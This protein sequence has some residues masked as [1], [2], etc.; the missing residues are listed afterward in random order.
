[1]SRIFALPWSEILNKPAIGDL[2][3]VLPL[4]KLPAHTHSWSDISGVLPIDKLPAHTHSNLVPYSGAT[5]AL[6]LGSQNLLT[7]GNLTANRVFLG[8]TGPQLDSSSGTIRA[9][10]NAN[11]ADAPFSA[12]NITSSGVG[13][14]A[15]SSSSA[16]VLSLADTWSSSGVNYTGL[17]FNTTRTAQGSSSK[18]F[19]FQSNGVDVC[20]LD[21]NGAL[22]VTSFGGTRSILAS[23]AIN[24]P[25]YEVSSNGKLWFSDGAAYSTAL[26]AASSGVLQLT[27][28]TSGTYRDLLLQNLTASGSVNL[29]TITA[30]VKSSNNPASTASSTTNSAVMVTGLRDGVEQSIKSYRGRWIFDNSA[31]GPIITIGDPGGAENF[32]FLG[33]GLGMPIGSG[34]IGLWAQHTCRFWVSPAACG[35]TNALIGW[36]TTPTIWLDTY[37]KKNGV[38]D[39]SLCQNP[40]NTGEIAANF[41]TGGLTASGNVTVGGTTAPTIA[42]KNASN[43]TYVQ[44]DGTNRI[45]FAGGDAFAVLTSDGTT[46][47]YNNGA[48]AWN[49]TSVASSGTID[50]KLIRSATAQVGVR[51]DAGLQVMNLAGSAYTTLYCNMVEV[52]PTSSSIFRRS[53]YFVWRNPSDG[54]IKFANWAETGGVHMDFT[55]ADCVGIKN[56]ANNG[57]GAL[58]QGLVSSTAAANTTSLPGG[59]AWWQDTTGNTRR[60]NYNDSGVIYRSPL[61]I[62]G[63]YDHQPTKLCDKRQLVDRYR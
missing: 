18:F 61:L 21:S 37:F 52:A 42:F 27:N 40:S 14:F 3:G 15:G 26:H 56:L 25:T 60:F 30:G 53:G 22:N 20:W 28:G 34:N 44:F 43:S 4:D 50:A 19:A 48:L 36:N 59:A 38:G 6:D 46:R 5:G 10:N 16:P 13:S 51:A 58:K 49:S 47:L 39:I 57:F 23:Q 45:F 17:K 9:R 35:T 62:S 32:G 1:M 33:S 31:G 2:S 11:N 41:T 29:S 7:T 63:N 54:V 24:A 8:S 12:S 55:A